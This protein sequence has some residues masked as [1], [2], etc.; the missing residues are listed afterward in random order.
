LQGLL[1]ENESN[2]KW[3]NN[4]QLSKVNKIHRSVN[5]MD[6]LESCE[7]EREKRQQKNVNLMPSI[8]AKLNQHG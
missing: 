7:S 4:G 8:L 5:T 2:R 1:I 6:R 3:L